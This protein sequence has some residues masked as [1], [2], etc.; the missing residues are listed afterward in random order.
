MDVIT[1][2]PKDLFE[3]TFG[4]Y[5]PQSDSCRCIRDLIAA[6]RTFRKRFTGCPCDRDLY[7]T[8]WLYERGTI[9]WKNS[10]VV[11]KVT[12]YFDSILE[13]ARWTVEQAAEWLFKNDFMT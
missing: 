9:S 12:H 1:Q 11:P 8:H 3:K 4:Y 7:L 10:R 5:T 13:N 6:H 2:L